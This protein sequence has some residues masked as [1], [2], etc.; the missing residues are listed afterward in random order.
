MKPPV[1]ISM[2]PSPSTSATKRLCEPGIHVPPT[3]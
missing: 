2:T 1:T 3:P